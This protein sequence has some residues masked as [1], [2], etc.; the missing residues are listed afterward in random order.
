MALYSHVVTVFII[1]LDTEVVT[2]LTIALDTQ[3]V[4]KVM[5]VFSTALDAGAMSVPIIAL[6]IQGVPVANAILHEGTKSPCKQ[7][8]ENVTSKKHYHQMKTKGREK[9]TFLAMEM[10]KKLI[11]HKIKTT[12]F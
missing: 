5:T 6:R 8:V 2:V 7:S 12:I 9:K 10:F 4:T 3:V 11:V 1:A